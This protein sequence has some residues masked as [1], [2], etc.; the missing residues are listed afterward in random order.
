MREIVGGLLPHYITAERDSEGALKDG[1]LVETLLKLLA[2]DPRVTAD[3][4]TGKQI[5]TVH[6]DHLN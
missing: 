2:A 5:V 1:P 4:V 3:T 6:G